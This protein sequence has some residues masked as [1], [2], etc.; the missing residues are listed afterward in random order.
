MLDTRFTYPIKA[1]NAYELSLPKCGIWSSSKKRVLI[2]FQTV[3]S[4]D[5]KNRELLAKE[6]TLTTVKNALKYGRQI[7]RTYK[8]N[9]TEA[10]Y[11]AVNFN[12]FRHLNL[13]VNARKAAE[14]EF[15]KRCH[16]V[17][18]KL[19]PTHVL[20]SGDQAMSAMFPQIESSA[21]KRGWVH[22]LKSGDLKLRVVST[23]DLARLLEKKGQLANLLGFWCRH[24]ANLLLG[25]HPHSLAHVKVECRYVDTIEKFDKLMKRLDKSEVIAVDTETAN[26]S[27][28]HNKIYTIQFAT[29][30]NPDVGYFLPLKHP[31]T[32]WTKDELKYIYSKLRRFFDEAEDTK[33]LVT[34]NGPYDLRVIR[35]E[36]KLPIIWHYVW[37]VM[38][39]EH[40]LDENLWD[41]ADF[42]T[43]SGGL[44]ATYCSYGNDFYYTAKFSKDE[45]ASAG[46]IKPNN[47]DFVLYGC[48]DVVSILHIREQQ[49][50]RAEHQFID[51]KIYKP[52]FKRHML[53]QMSDT[54]HQLSHLR[55]DGSLIDIK[56]LRHLISKE[57]P[58]LAEMKRIIKSLRTRP[59]VIKTNQELLADS[60]MKSRGLFGAV[61]KAT[62]WA[63]SFTKPTHL[64][65]LF[66]EVMGLDPVS[67]TAKGEDAVDKTFIKEYQD[68]NLVV[69][70][71]GEFAALKT[72]MST[73][74]RGWYKKVTSNKDSLT[75]S[76]LRPDYMVIDTGRLATR[77][78]S[79]QNIPT[80][81]VLAKIIKKMFPSPKGMLLIRFDYSAHEVRVWSIISFDTVLAAAFKIGQSLRQAW[82]KTPTDEIKKDIKLKGDIHIA[83]VK[84]LFN[85]IIDKSHPL[86]DAVKAVVFGL[87][88]GKSAKTL[89]VDT[90][91]GE[92]VEIKSKLK[93]LR[94]EKQLIEKSL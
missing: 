84:R 47:P 49:L 42:G 66:F 8:E 59:E 68:K 74:V 63:I 6:G 35:R 57:S 53:Y 17:I 81:G 92:L 11:A 86:R 41:L 80:H 13:S 18:Q 34:F 28:L 39:G 65:K 73:Y 76:H 85:K 44:A 87:L 4:R 27:V 58:L 3:D 91:K 46:S 25:Y 64:K 22:E 75:D 21:Y 52:Y 31:Q 55:E 2:I 83:N 90:K 15:A 9:S 10:A 43:A 24:F 56:Y 60:G 78:P 67:K 37:E 88:Y 61:S 40:D 69:A 71:Y 20:I 93:A 12:A 23:L 5:L 54:A 38:Y 32:H 33:E 62:S 30:L 36:F 16:K 29:D 19:K 1:E 94:D 77:N 48:T 89:G 50:K 7:A 51:G 72:L 26:L 82:I 70:D 79:L 45:R 14:I